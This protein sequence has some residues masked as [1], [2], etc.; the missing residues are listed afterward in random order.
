MGAI[1]RRSDTSGTKIAPPRI[2]E[3]N[4]SYIRPAE[5]GMRVQ[6][7]PFL[8]VARKRICRIWMAECS[9][10]PAGNHRMRNREQHVAVSDDRQ[11]VARRIV[12]AGAVNHARAMRKSG[13]FRA[14]WAQSGA[15]AIAAATRRMRM[16]AW[17]G[18]WQH[19]LR[20][21]KENEGEGGRGGWKEGKR[22]G[23]WKSGKK[24]TNEKGVQST[25]IRPG[26]YCR[27][28]PIRGQ[29]GRTEGWMKP[30][31]RERMGTSGRTNGAF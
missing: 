22:K 18:R 29:V 1:S 25:L 11:S 12:A 30:W 3:H 6:I 24:A 27:P 2:S 9:P 7:S 16:E 31:K 5:R 20:Q 14:R 4:S 10:S 8:S 15:N 21:G 28:R 23:E 19:R 17:G 13:D 26:R